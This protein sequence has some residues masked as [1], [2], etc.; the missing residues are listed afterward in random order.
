MALVDRRPW[1]GVG[2]FGRTCTA[3]AKE[4]D[5]YNEGV[6]TFIDKHFQPAYDAGYRRFIYWLP[7]GGYTQV[8]NSGNCPATDGVSKSQSYVSATVDALRWI[9]PGGQGAIP[10]L[11]ILGQYPFT[12][13]NSNFGFSS[14]PNHVGNETS[15]PCVPG[16]PDCYPEGSIEPGYNTNLLN[17][18]DDLLSPE[19]ALQTWLNTLDSTVEFSFYVGFRTIVDQ[20]PLINFIKGGVNKPDYGPLNPRVIADKTFEK[21]DGT[22]ES[23]RDF[24]DRNIA[25]LIAASRAPE[26]YSKKIYVDNGSPADITERIQ[27]QS[28]PT[29]GARYTMRE[30]ASYIK[31]NYDAEVINEA[32]PTKAGPFPTTPDYGFMVDGALALYQ[33]LE[34]TP[35]GTGRD[36]GTWYFPKEYS[37]LMCAFASNGGW[38]WDERFTGGEASGFEGVAKAFRQKIDQ[39]YVPGAMA[40]FARQATPGGQGIANGVALNLMRYLKNDFFSNDG[41]RYIYEDDDG[42]NKYPYLELP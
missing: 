30:Y 33:F 19:G 39:G 7:A 17:Y 29:G 41:T 8:L 10:Q 5:F 34:G 2:A 9:S 31:A 40:Q 28:D 4:T 11:E 36:E 23:F 20:N 27:D 38:A 1:F 14:L 42:N 26:G 21:T 16:N 22:I 32:I 18:Y 12:D 13:S 3:T 6:Q 24:V 15:G 35:T 25:P 37:N